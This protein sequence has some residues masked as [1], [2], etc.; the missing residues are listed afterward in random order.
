MVGYNLTSILK[1]GYLALWDL[2]TSKLL[3]Q[4]YVKP[5]ISDE[6]TK[7]DHVHIGIN[8]F[9]YNRQNNDLFVHVFK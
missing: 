3:N 8:H 6:N 5:Y 7:N 4:F 1:D 9:D 2:N